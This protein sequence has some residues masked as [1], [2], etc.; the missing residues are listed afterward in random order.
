MVRVVEFKCS[1]ASLSYIIFSQCLP[2]D[3]LTLTRNSISVIFIIIA[4]FSELVSDYLDENKFANVAVVPV[5]LM[6]G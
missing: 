4:K 1:F 3:R 2:D 5:F 6:T